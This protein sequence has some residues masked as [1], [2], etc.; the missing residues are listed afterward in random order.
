MLDKSRVGALVVIMAFAVVGCASGLPTA[1][2]IA[3]PDPGPTGS[4]ASSDRSGGS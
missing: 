1:D 3:P 2:A 4:V